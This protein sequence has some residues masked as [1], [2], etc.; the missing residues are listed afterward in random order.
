VTSATAP[1]HPQDPHTADPLGPLLA[2]RILDAVRPDGTVTPVS[3]QIGLPGPHPDHVGD[4]S[5]PCRI[6]GLGDEE[7]WT[8]YGVDALEAVAEA[9]ELLR[10]IL[11][12]LARE[13]RLTF[14]WG[15]EGD[16]DVFDVLW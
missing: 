6:Q 14:G 10:R 2:N 15:E 13:E 4:W 5:C 12:D 9:L 7:V 8:V 11:V 16:L 3:V 1:N